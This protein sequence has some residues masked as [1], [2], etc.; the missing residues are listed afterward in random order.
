MDYDKESPAYL[1]YYP[2]Q[3][4]VKRVRRV[5]FLDSFMHVP[6]QRVVMELNTEQDENPPEIINSAHEGQNSRYPTRV[7]NMP[8]GQLCCRE[9]HR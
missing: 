9:R 4:K 8:F 1:V 6:E 2:K 5:K 3:N 7:R